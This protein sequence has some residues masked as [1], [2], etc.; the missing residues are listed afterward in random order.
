MYTGNKAEIDIKPEAG[1]VLSRIIYNG[2][3]EKEINPNGMV[4]KTPPL[5]E[6]AVIY[7]YFSEAETNP[8]TIKI[9]SAPKIITH[10]EDIYYFGKVYASLVP[11]EFGILLSDNPEVTEEDEKIT[12]KFSP[13]KNTGSFGFQLKNKTK[14]ESLVVYLRPYAVYNGVM[15]LGEIIKIDW[16]SVKGILD[17]NSIQ[18]WLENNGLNYSGIMDYMLDE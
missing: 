1:W 12:A 7:V 4:Y 5:S 13:D 9:Y 8:E 10:G 17:E 6:N 18:G 3:D 2:E 11:D 16:D 15:N 14:N